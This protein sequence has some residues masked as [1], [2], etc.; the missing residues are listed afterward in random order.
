[1]VGFIVY[2]A[3]NERSCCRPSLVLVDW[4]ASCI[5]LVLIR[6]RGLVCQVPLSKRVELPPGTGAEACI[7]ECAMTRIVSVCECAGRRIR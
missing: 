1:M 2:C 4:Q 5:L 3:A 6:V 7:R